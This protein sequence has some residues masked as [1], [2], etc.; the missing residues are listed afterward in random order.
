MALTTSGTVYRGGFGPFMSGVNVTPFP[1]VTRG[2]YGFDDAKAWPAQ[3]L[4]A[5]EGYNYWGA[6]P[7]SV[8]DRDTARCLES[9]ELL[10]RTQSPPSDTAAVLL[11]P[12]L[13]EGGYVPCPPGFLRGLREIC[14]K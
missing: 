12:V 1:Y 6:A 10:L 13:G 7:R 5:E 11:E 8:A 4:A 9:L 3:S 14:D 2:P